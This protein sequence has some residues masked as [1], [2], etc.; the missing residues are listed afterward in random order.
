M[1]IKTPPD[2]RMKLHNVA[3]D[4]QFNEAVNSLA[5][6]F[7]VKYSGPWSMHVSC[8]KDFL[9]NNAHNVMQVYAQQLADGNVSPESRLGLDNALTEEQTASL[10]HLAP[11][12]PEKYKAALSLSTRWHA[13][14]HAALEAFSDTTYS[15]HSLDPSDSVQTVTHNMDI[16]AAEQPDVAVELAE[17]SGGSV[18]LLSSPTREQHAAGPAISLNAPNSVSRNSLSVKASKKARKR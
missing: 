6:T 12:S 16:D 2:L 14:P 1:Y 9:A 5:G 17:S 7:N 15:L 18:E 10:L 3:N 8:G 11:A 4:R 13:V